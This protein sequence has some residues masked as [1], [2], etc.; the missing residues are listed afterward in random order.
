MWGCV[1][2]GMDSIFIL[3]ARFKSGSGCVVIVLVMCVWRVFYGVHFLDMCGVF[4][5]G[6]L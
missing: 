3:R 5:F 6:V 4:I 2:M 1:G